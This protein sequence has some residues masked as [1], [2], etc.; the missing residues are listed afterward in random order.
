MEQREVDGG[1]QGRGAEPRG[2]V[3]EVER[4]LTGVSGRRGRGC[5]SDNFNE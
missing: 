5:V 1:D 3:G 2:E 4:P